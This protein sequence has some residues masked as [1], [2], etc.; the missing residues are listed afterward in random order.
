MIRLRTHS[1]VGGTASTCTETDPKVASAASRPAQ[2]M[3]HWLR[4]TKQPICLVAFSHGSSRTRPRALRLPRTVVGDGPA[5]ARDV[6]AVERADDLRFEEGAPPSIV[7]FGRLIP[8]I[9]PP[10]VVRR[11]RL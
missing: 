10:G 7:A 8:A 9:S 5:G 6:Q 3:L 4:V 1:S 2:P 11:V